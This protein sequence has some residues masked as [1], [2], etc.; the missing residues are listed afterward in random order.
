MMNIVTLQEVKS[1]LRIDHDFDDADLQ[2]KIN[3]ATAAVFDHVKSWVER[4]QGDETKLKQSPDF[5][6]VKDAILILIGIIDR[7]REGVDIA[8]YPQG[9]LPYPV[10]CLLGSMHQPT[11]L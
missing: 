1:H 6:R 9:L 11:I 5:Y 2:L 4:F 7:D 10:T 3:A 8:L